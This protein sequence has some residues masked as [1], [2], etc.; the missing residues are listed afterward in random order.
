MKAEKLTFGW[1]LASLFVA[2]GISFNPGKAG[3]RIRRVME[4]GKRLLGLQ[5]G[6]AG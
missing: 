2:V 3:Y 4:K 6:M 1:V 5:G